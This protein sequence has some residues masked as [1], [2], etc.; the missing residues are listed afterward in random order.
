MIVN[1]NRQKFLRPVLTDHI[2]VKKLVDLLRLVKRLNLAQRL[3]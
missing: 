3:R 1:G 2:L